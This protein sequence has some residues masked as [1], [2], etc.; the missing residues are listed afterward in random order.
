MF[1]ELVSKKSSKIGLG[2]LR[3]RG[4][5]YCRC[6]RAT[7]L[8]GVD[9]AKP[10]G[11]LLLGL[12]RALRAADILNFRDLDYKDTLARSSPVTKQLSL[13][14]SSDKVPSCHG[15]SISSSRNGNYLDSIGAS[16]G[17]FN[18]CRLK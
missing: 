13:S 5:D 11:A 15:G 10:A 9:G 7:E 2:S 4:G 17:P 16:G 12:D 18:S 1:R 8:I 3:H 6:R 14:C